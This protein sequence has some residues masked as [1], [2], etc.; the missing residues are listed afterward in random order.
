[1]AKSALLQGQAMDIL[2]VEDDPAIGKAQ[3][4]GLTE[5]G[6]QCVWVK[7]GTRGL[8][9]ALGQQFDA[10]VLDL[11]LP[12]EPGL[13]VL[14]KL[15]AAGVR[16]PVIVLTALGSVEERVAGLKAGADDYIVK[17]FAMVELLARL[18]AVCR[19]AVTR[20]VA[21]LEVSDIRLELATRRV[22]CGGA[23]I[24]LTPTEFSLLELLMRHAGQVVTRRMLCEHLWEADWEGTTNVIEVHINRLRNKLQRGRP[25]PLIQ[26]VRGRG[27]ALRAP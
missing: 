4:R 25:E 14:G 20:P 3:Q 9:R 12:G 13:S 16:T 7:D 26:T 21:T 22:S 24:D 1:M 18:E 19:R 5:S 17:P 6:H 11:L 15:R 2:I 23:D 27:Y 8:E 10:I